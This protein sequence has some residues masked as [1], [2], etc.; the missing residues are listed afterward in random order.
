MSAAGE[1]GTITLLAALDDA[2]HGAATVWD[3]A[4]AS[5]FDGQVHRPYAG[6]AWSPGE[7]PAG[8]RGV[9]CPA[10]LTV[11]KPG[12]M[13]S[14][15]LVALIERPAGVARG[16]AWRLWAEHVPL[17]VAVHHKALSYRQFRLGPPA[18][19]SAPDYTGMAVLSFASEED[20]RTGLYR[21]AGDIGLIEA[22]IGRFVARTTAMFCAQREAG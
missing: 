14:I 11:A 17:A 2:G 15:Q 18:S 10:W 21:D 9:H 5:P 6:V 7:G 16:T 20:L 8:A 4:R 19:P 13:G 12:P 3:A 22:D 1:A